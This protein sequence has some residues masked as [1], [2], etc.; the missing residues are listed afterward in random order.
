MNHGGKCIN[1]HGHEYKIEITAQAPNLDR[2]GMI[3][4][5]SVLKEKFQPWF[6]ENW[7]HTFI[8]NQDDVDLIEI[9]SNPKIKNTKPIYIAPFN[10]T[11]ENMAAF[12]RVHLAPVLLKG[13]N[14][15][16]V[17]VI[18]YETENCWAESKKDRIP[19]IP[20]EVEMLR[21]Y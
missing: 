7:D 16:V 14:I 3:I 20:P 6:D 19:N 8:V 10:P 17:S 11:A 4:D 12:I 9:L 1:L 18:V 2:L 15:E 21:K 5:F 13:Y